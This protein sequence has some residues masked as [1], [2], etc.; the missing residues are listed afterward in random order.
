M[1]TSLKWLVEKVGK[2][3]VIGVYEDNDEGSDKARLN[4][5]IEDFIHAKIDSIK[6]LKLNRLTHVDGNLKPILQPLM[7]S[8]NLQHVKIYF[9]MEAYGYIKDMM[10]LKELKNLKSIS[11][12]RSAASFPDNYYREIPFINVS[13]NLTFLRIESAAMRIAQ[14][15]LIGRCCQHLETLRIE[16]EDANET[17]FTHFTIRQLQKF[18]LEFKSANTI[19]EMIITNILAS[20]QQPIQDPMYGEFSHICET[21]NSQ[22]RREAQRF[23]VPALQDRYSSNC[24]VFI[25]YSDV[26][27][28][29]TLADSDDEGGNP[30]LSGTLIVKDKG[31]EKVTSEAY[32]QPIFDR[33]F[34]H[35]DNDPYDTFG[36]YVLKSKVKERM[37]QPITDWICTL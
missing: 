27:H 11:I 19:Q 32:D 22:V 31:I 29:M 14:L 34:D 23:L 3:E 35:I 26:H 33:Y 24:F 20:D 16:G 30:N 36:D 9:N 5:V 2:I 4:K 1:E 6:M 17:A 13:N 25:L 7:K 18:L 21:S 37:P 10:L 28:L 15:L 12:D 8:T